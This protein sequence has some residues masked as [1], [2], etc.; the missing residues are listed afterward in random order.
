MLAYRTAPSALRARYV[1]RGSC[2]S[3]GHRVASSRAQLH[4]A[5]DVICFH[6]CRCCTCGSSNA[7]LQIVDAGRKQ[8]RQR[9]NFSISSHWTRAAKPL[10]DFSIKPIANS[11]SVHLL[12]LG[13]LI[14][15]PFGSAQRSCE[16]APRLAAKLRRY[17]QLPIAS[18]LENTCRNILVGCGIAGLPGNFVIDGPACRLKIHH[19][20]H[21]FEQRRM[22]PL[23]FA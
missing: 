13:A 11:P 15:D 18:G 12:V 17:D 6:I 7:L 14:A 5:R 21:R 22:Q 8:R 2:A 9:F 4:Q 23:P 19:I 20:K 16:I 10:L 1:V 3:R